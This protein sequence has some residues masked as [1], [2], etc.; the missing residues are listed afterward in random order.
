MS[1]CKYYNLKNIII[2]L[3]KLKKERK[4]NDFEF[5]KWEGLRALLVTLLFNQ[6]WLPIQ[7]CS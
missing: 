1:N 6:G 5:S 3:T 7:L 2:K 4:F